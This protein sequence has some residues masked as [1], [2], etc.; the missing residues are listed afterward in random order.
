M[1]GSSE[2]EID[3]ILEE[4]IK[5]NNRWEGLI[6]ETWYTYHYKDGTI[7]ETWVHPLKEHWPLIRLKEKE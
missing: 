4:H 5:V 7:I 3:Y 1:A 6:T 2:K